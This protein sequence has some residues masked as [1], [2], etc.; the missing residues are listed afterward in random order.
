M[1][2][3]PCFALL[4]HARPFFLSLAHHR[5]PFLLRPPSL[6]R[7][8]IGEIGGLCPSKWSEIGDLTERW[9]EIGVLTDIEK[10]ENE[11]LK[12]HNPLTWR[13][14]SGLRAGMARRPLEA[15][16]NAVF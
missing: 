10:E 2:R 8:Q 9:S 3:A 16:E 5:P 11:P 1:F 13:N 7:T 12:K 4:V 14:S 15:G 6:A